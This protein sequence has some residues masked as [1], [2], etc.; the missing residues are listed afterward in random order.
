MDVHID[1]TVDVPVAKRRRLHDEGKRNQDGQEAAFRLRTENKKQIVFDGEGPNDLRFEV[2]YKQGSRVVRCATLT[3]PAKT[4]VRIR[5]LRL[6]PGGPSEPFHRSGSSS[7]PWSATSTFLCQERV[8]DVDVVAPLSILEETV[9]VMKLT[10]LERVR[11]RTI[12][13]RTFK[14]PHTQYQ[15]RVVET[16]IAVAVLMGSKSN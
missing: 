3:T 16:Y 2:R 5:S 13:Q 10:P 9:A 7:A 11:Q 12:E 4:V 14:V 6:F 1:T 15:D 8:P